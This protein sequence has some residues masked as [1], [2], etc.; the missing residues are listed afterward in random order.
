MSGLVRDHAPN[1][2]SGGAFALPLF[3]FSFEHDPEK[4]N[5]VFRPDHAQTKREQIMIRLIG[6]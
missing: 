5:P 3:C 6:S 4:W 2:I 1:K